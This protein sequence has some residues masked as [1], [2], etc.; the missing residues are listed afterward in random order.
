VLAVVTAVL[1]GRQ[2]LSGDAVRAVKE[3]W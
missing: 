1:G 2:A 3:D